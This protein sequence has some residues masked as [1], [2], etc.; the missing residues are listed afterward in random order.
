MAQE[1]VSVKKNFVT[2]RNPL[3]IRTPKEILDDSQLL[4]KALAS[5]ILSGGVEPAAKILR[6]MKCS[7]LIPG[8]NYGTA[9][10]IADFY[11]VTEQYTRGIFLKYHINNA[12]CDCVV[13]ESPADFL[14]KHGDS[15]C[16]YESHGHVFISQQGNGKI[17][18]VD[19][20]GQ[21]Y[22]A[23]VIL[24]FACLAVQCRRTV[25]NSVANK[26]MKQ[27]EKSKI[28]KAVIEERSAANLKS[29]MQTAAPATMVSPAPSTVMIS[30][31]SDGVIMSHGDFMTL[32]QAVQAASASSPA[33]PLDN[34]DGKRKWSRRPL[35]LPDNWDRIL[36]EYKDGNI[37]AKEA[38]K[39]A[40]MCYNSFHRYARKSS[41]QTMPS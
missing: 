35:T 2:S 12:L 21:Y 15:S 34:P 20:R 14:K 31:R 17:Q 18:T 11:G 13:R 24:A 25:T 30:V 41:S 26:V 9:K 3:D 32:M 22:D 16:R 39:L 33:V 19:S 4:H 37:K 6:K 1:N 10:S 28:A 5:A 36:S 40:G 27:I 7:A 23:R 38:A 29:T 8:T